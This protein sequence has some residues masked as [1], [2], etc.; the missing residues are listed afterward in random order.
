MERITIETTQNVAIE[1]DVASIGER[2]VAEIIDLLI[3][4][5]YLFSI[6]RIVALLGYAM[7]DGGLGIVFSFCHCQSFFTAFI[8]RFCCMARHRVKV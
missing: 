6:W 1:Y 2:I 3:M 7:G 5:G 8:L 4:G